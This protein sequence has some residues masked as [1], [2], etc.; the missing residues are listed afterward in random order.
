MSQLEISKILKDSIPDL[1]L[2]IITYHDIVVGDSPQMLKGRLDFFQEAIKVEADSKPVSEIPE[3]DE[4]RKIFKSVGTDPSK[5][6]PS[7]EALY[8]R[9]YKGTNLGFIHS[10]ADTNNFFSLEYK[11]PMG[12][13]DL[14]EI[15]GPI[16]VTIGESSDQYEGINGRM[17]NMENKIVMKDQI[18]A[19]GSPIVDSKRTMLTEASK[20]ALQVVYFTPSIPMD[21]AEKMLQAIQKMFTQINGGEAAVQ[22]IC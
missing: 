10:G 20:H 11:I 18:S 6:R 5:Y 17:M 2:G 1:K 14:D 16:T 7:S 8:R 12:I 15:D 21:H 9:I 19:F 13:Y 3:I 4:W 22:I